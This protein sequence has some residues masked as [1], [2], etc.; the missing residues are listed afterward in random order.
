MVE[1]G[2]KYYCY[3]HEKHVAAGAAGLAEGLE[4]GPLALGEV[5]PGVARLQACDVIT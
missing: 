1:F 3:T 2:E 4:V 5:G